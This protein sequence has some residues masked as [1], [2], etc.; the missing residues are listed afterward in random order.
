MPITDFFLSQE[1]EFQFVHT[2]NFDICFT[3][4]FAK[5]RIYDVHKSKYGG[6]S[7]KLIEATEGVPHKEM[8]YDFIMQHT[9]K[10]NF[11]LPSLIV[12]VNDLV[13]SFKY[14]SK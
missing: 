5:L 13:T 10:Y 4:S 6:T 11:F 9:Q 7:K 12:E 14:F 1:N 2:D 8:T 3:D